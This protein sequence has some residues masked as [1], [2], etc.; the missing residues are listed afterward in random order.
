[1]LALAADDPVCSRASVALASALFSHHVL[2]LGAIVKRERRK[3]W[4]V[5]L[6]LVEICCEAK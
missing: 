5:S 4:C 3:T 1:M 2:V 6:H